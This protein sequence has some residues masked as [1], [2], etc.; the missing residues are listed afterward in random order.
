MKQLTYLGQNGREVPLSRV[1]RRQCGF[2][3]RRENRLVLYS[4]QRFPGR[5]P[6]RTVVRT[7]T[8][9]PASMRLG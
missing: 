7:E 8:K 9:F 4:T 3:Q 2:S 1:V 6:F 5:G